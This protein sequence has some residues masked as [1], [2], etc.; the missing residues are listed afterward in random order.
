MGSRSTGWN[1]SVVYCGPS[2]I[3]HFDFVWMLPLLQRNEHPE[4]PTFGKADKNRCAMHAWLVIR[5]G[6]QYAVKCSNLYQFRDTRR[7]HGATK[8]V[9]FLQAFTKLVWG[10]IITAK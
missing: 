6:V 5:M 4:E 9:S 3:G 10:F 1:W 2:R 8:C 7:K